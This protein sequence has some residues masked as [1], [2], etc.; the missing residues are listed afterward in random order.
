MSIAWGCVVVSS[1]ASWMSAGRE[2]R[3][4]ELSGAVVMLPV[5]VG[6]T[7]AVTCCMVS[8]ARCTAR[9]ALRAEMCWTA[10]FPNVARCSMSG[11]F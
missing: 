10:S 4:S 1:S 3:T 2:A 11:L 7:V 5:M 6:M 9:S 8:S